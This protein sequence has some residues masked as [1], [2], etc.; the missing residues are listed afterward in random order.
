MIQVAPAAGPALAEAV[1]P[2][3]PWSSDMRG[4]WKSLAA[5]KCDFFVVVVIIECSETFRF[6]DVDRLEKR[7]FRSMYVVVL[8]VVSR[9]RPRRLLGK[10]GLFRAPMG[11]FAIK[12]RS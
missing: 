2:R 11:A 6:G 8:V 9:L 7:K 3:R 10:C 1:A 12:L 5:N 4:C